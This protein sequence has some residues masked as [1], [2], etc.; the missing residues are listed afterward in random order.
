MGATSMN[1]IATGEQEIVHAGR[2]YTVAYSAEGRC[3][4]I[5]AILGGPPEDCHPD[6][7]E[8]E[9]VSITALWA[10]DNTGEL[11]EH[12]PA[13]DALGKLLD[14]ADVE[15]ALWAAYNDEDLEV[16]GDDE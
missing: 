15:A 16:E 14:L 9:I 6:E 10:T 5:P 3:I 11:I 8:C 13:L 4:Y 12:A 2:T 7:S 1:T